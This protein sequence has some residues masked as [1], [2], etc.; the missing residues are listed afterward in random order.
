MRPSAVVGHSTISPC[1]LVESIPDELRFLK[2]VFGAQ[3]KQQRG[4]HEGAVWQVE[5]RLGD[6]VLKIGRAHQ[7]DP[8]ATGML[9]VRTD[10]VDATYAR[11]IQKGATL[12]SA[13]TDQPS[14]VREARFRDPQGHIWWIGQQVRKLSNREVERRLAEQRRKRL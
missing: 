3:V 1:L 4:E 6:A 7:A 2:A 13:P 11:A 8:P 14:G 9:Y 12:I 10:D 5:V